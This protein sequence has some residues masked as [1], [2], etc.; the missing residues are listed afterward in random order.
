[1]NHPRCALVLETEEESGSPNLL[2]LLDLAKE[3][4]GKPDIML[5]M[6][7]GAFDYERLWITSSLRGITVMD[8]TVEGCSQGI[9]SGEVGGV[10]PE[11]FTVV[12]NLLD[13]I[14]SSVNQDV[15]EELKVEVPEHVRE[16]AKF[17]AGLSGDQMWKK[18]GLNEGV[19]AI[20]HENLEEL[21]LNNVW[22]A[23]LS[24]VGQAGLPDLPVAGNVVRPST[25]VRLS[26]RL[27]P[28]QN[29][30]QMT[31]IIEKKLTTDVPHGAKVTIRRGG[32]GS[33]WARKQYHDW[34]DKSLH[35]AGKEFYDGKDAACYGMGGSIP[36]LAE[37]Q[38]M[39][40]DC[41]IIALGLIGPKSNAHAPDEA[42][43]L[44]YAKKLTAALSHIVADIG[45]N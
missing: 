1:L 9:H 16:E 45:N 18:Y 4:I 42:M 25:S 15:C 43:N 5:C 21:Y 32:S 39:Y 36:F 2:E 20:N 40:P 26:C 37:L 27:G 12:R 3:A 35:D 23:S 19:K 44:P 29:P 11:T 38:G 30:A 24:I 10:I 7:S 14:D 8:L 41:Q 13:R 22:R 28:T 6:D 17:M 34:L 33:G 31:E